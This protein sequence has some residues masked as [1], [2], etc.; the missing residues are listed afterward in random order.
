M[1]IR[2]YSNQDLP[3]VTR[4]QVAERVTFQ[5]CCQ[6]QNPNLTVNEEDILE[7]LGMDSLDVVELEL[8]LEDEYFQFEIE[9]FLEPL[10]ISQ[11]SVK[12]VI[13]TLYAALVRD[14]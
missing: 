13:D 3:T 14:K 12:E 4:E 7:D 2:V 11:P 8:A 1:G 9:N 10:G 6:L 5:I